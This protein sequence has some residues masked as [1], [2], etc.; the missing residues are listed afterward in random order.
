MADYVAL[1]TTGHILLEAGGG[2]LLEVQVPV[3]PSATHP[4]DWSPQFIQAQQLFYA[5]QQ[6]LLE[7][8][9]RRDGDQAQVEPADWLD[10]D[11]LVALTLLLDV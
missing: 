7:A 3:V 6:R 9:R 2:L 4:D 8:K 10:D 11:L 5:Q 1:E